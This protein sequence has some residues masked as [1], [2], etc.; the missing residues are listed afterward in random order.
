MWRGRMSQGMDIWHT[1][2]V[3]KVLVLSRVR[4]LAGS[5]PK[6]F[7][8]PVTFCSPIFEDNEQAHIVHTGFARSSNHVN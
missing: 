8:S 6:N 2:T 5:R 3:L 1:C 4:S 7:S